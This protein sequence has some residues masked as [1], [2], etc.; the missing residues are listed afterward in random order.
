MTYKNEL[1]SNVSKADFS[2][3]LP[4]QNVNYN[5]NP[6]YALDKSKCKALFKLF[7]MCSVCYR[8]EHLSNLVPIK[9]RALKIHEEEELE[10]PN[11]SYV[12]YY[13]TPFSIADT[14][15]ICV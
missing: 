14:Y 10:L 8:P 12:L 4:I 11:P 6:K 7:E 2:S 3:R 9:H 1:N 13:P 15:E 5:D